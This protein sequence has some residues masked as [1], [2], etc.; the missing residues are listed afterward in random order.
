MQI[1]R[2]WVGRVLK[3]QVILSGNNLVL[4]A[5]VYCIPKHLMS[6]GWPRGRRIL[7]QIISLKG[8][9]KQGIIKNIQDIQTQMNKME[10]AHLQCLFVDLQDLKLINMIPRNKEFRNFL[11]KQKN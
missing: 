1:R 11:T 10:V 9:G 8:A 5:N 2:M 4:Y 6:R 7:V 3:S